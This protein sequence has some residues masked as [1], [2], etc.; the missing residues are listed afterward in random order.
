MS[1][2]T[3]VIVL[4]V[5]GLLLWLV[6]TYIPM[7]PTIKRIIDALVIIVVVLWLLQVFGVLGAAQ[8]VKIVPL[9]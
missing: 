7:N 9:R 5:V 2:I 1:L 3:I 8:S 4:I 6:E